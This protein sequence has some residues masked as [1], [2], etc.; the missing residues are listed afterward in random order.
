V[1]AQGCFKKLNAESSPKYVFAYS[2]PK[3]AR[4]YQQLQANPELVQD[5]SKWFAW[6]YYKL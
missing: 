6:K 1:D 2:I 5:P 4:I 3:I